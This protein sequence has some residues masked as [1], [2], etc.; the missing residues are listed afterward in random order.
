MPIYRVSAQEVNK[1]VFNFE[2]Y[3]PGFARSLLHGALGS[4]RVWLIQN[5]VLAD[6][7]PPGSESTLVKSAREAYDAAERD[8]KKKTNARDVEQTDLEKDYGPDDVFRALKGKC[9]S[10]EAGEYTYELCWLDKTTQKSKKGH[11]TT[12][13]GYFGSVERGVA[14]DEDRLDGKSL[15]RGERIILRYENGQGC[16]NGPNRKTEVWLGCA[17]TEELWR[18]SESEKCVYKMEVGTPAVCEGYK[19][20]G[21]VKDEL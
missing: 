16:W 9:V 6:N 3:L 5:G 20:E 21:P 12:N 11:G 19:V 2:A 17:E 13:M 15:G 18:V 8:L 14:D 10:T 1:P 7:V 4:V